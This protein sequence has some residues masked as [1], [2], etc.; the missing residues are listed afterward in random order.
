MSSK[1]IKEGHT[2][3]QIGKHILSYLL[4]KICIDFL[5]SV[6]PC[7]N[8]L[9]IVYLKFVIVYTIFTHILIFTFEP[10]S[11]LFYHRRAKLIFQ[12]LWKIFLQFIDTNLSRYIN[13][14][15]VLFCTNDYFGMRHLCIRFSTALNEKKIY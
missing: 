6:F 8:R 13:I 1:I 11:I 9:S 3:T 2:T 7:Q 5:F 14:I 15:F 4:N 12:I 10:Q